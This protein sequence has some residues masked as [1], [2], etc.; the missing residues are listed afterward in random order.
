M[1]IQAPPF[2]C[3][4]GLRWKRAIVV[5]A[6]IALPVA[7]VQWPWPFLPLRWQYGLIRDADIVVS[8]A[9]RL[10]ATL[11]RPPTWDE[12]HQAVPDPLTADRLNYAPDGDGYRLSIICGFDCSVGYESRSRQWK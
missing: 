11:H 5:I 7:V 2:D 10:T 12:L 9:D 4:V 8:A 1:K 6:L 3:R